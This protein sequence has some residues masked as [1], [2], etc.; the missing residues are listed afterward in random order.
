MIQELL[1]N[2]PET[3]VDPAHLETFFVILGMFL[4]VSLALLL[5]RGKKSTLFV[6]I[7]VMFSSYQTIQAYE[8]ERYM[9]DYN[10]WSE[11]IAEEVKESKVT[12]SEVVDFAV[13]STEKIEDEW[14]VAG[15]V[16]YIDKGERKEYEGYVVLEIKNV[17]NSVLTYNKLNEDLS[18]SIKKGLYYPTVITNELPTMMNDEAFKNEHSN[19]FF[20][21]KI[22][23]TVTTNWGKMFIVL[24]LILGLIFLL[25]LVSYVR[26]K[27]REQRLLNRANEEFVGETNENRELEQQVDYWENE[28]KRLRKV[29]EELEEK[30][31]REKIHEE[32]EQEPRKIRI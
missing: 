6:L 4:L 10:E 5:V 20:S 15:K 2:K 19:A 31:G 12:T 22:E 13:Y 17:E 3:S 11:K 1:K 25:K 16:I 29:V 9:K 23:R 30:D 21:Y 26:Y 18:F 27:R 8:Y 28:A 32:K 24:T 7:V 14:K